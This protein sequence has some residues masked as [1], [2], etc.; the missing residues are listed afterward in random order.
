MKTKIYLLNAFGVDSQGGNPAGV[1]LDAD[2]LTDIQKKYISKEIGYSE[3]AF[4]QKSNKADFKV[5]FFTPTEE[6]DLCGHATIATYALLLE[7]KIITE[8]A[9]TQELKAG[10]LKVAAM[11][12]RTIIMDQSLPI[13][14]ENP[15][16][17]EIIDIFSIP[18]EA[19]TQTGLEPQIVST[20]LKDVILPIKDRKSLFS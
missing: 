8:K 2:S 4:V 17:D 19:I 11:P 13:Y 5:T 16:L 15:P 20:G 18:A 1:V 9:Y 10:I 6:V 3:T 14:Y 7:K 12:D